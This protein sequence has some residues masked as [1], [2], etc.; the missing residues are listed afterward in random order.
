MLCDTCTRQ[1]R[2]PPWQLAQRDRKIAA[3]LEQLKR[4][5]LRIQV[6]SHVSQPSLHPPAR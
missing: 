6:A 2:C 5:A 4:C 1:R 3:M